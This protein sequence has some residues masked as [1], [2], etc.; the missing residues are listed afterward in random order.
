LKDFDNSHIIGDGQNPPEA[1]LIF[2]R[3]DFGDLPKT[4]VLDSFDKDQRPL[5]AQEPQIFQSGS[6]GQF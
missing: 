3:N 4:D 2:G 1:N 5:Y 6:A